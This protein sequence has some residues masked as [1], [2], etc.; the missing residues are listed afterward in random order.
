M[1]YEILFLGK[2]K[3]SF[4]TDGIS[5]Y[6]KRL[7]HYS[8][9]TIKT[10][11]SGKIQGSDALIKEK[12]CH[13]LQNNINSSSFLV[14]LDSQGKQFS[15]PGF[16]SLINGWERSGYKHIT[17]VIGGPLGFTQE[18]LKNADLLISF[19]KMTFTH[20]MVRLFL[21]EQLYRAYTIKAGEKY[22][23]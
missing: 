23:K 2:T 15:S 14:A 7:K 1:K 5:G 20:D 10:L 12:E 22:H 13:L 18:F 3:D 16:A 21:L 19:S 9:V 4:L 8:N 11:K 17:F 6:I